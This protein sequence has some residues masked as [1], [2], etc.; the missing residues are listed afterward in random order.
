MLALEENKNRRLDVE[1]SGITREKDDAIEVARLVEVKMNQALY[2]AKL[3]QK[4]KYH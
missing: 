3:Q 4:E 2:Q 1:F